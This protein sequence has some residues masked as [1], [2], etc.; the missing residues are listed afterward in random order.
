MDVAERPGA[1]LRTVITDPRLRW[2]DTFS[3]GADGAIYI[4]A[5][6]IQDSPWFKLQT[7]T[8]PS[9]IFRISPVR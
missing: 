8:T 7:Q 4:T 1:P 2:P 6:H 3:E 5:S 9:A